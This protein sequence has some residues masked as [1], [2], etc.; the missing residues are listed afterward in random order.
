MLGQPQHV[1]SCPVGSVRQQSGSGQL[2]GGAQNAIA[3]A[4]SCTPGKIR[5]PAARVLPAPM[6]TFSPSTTPP[7]TRQRSP[8]DTPGPMIAELIRAALAHPAAVEQHRA[9]DVGPGGHAH[10]PPQHGP[11]AEDGPREP[12]G[13]RSPP[14]RGRE[15]CRP[16][17]RPHPPSRSAPP[18][19]ASRR[20]TSVRHLAL[21]D[22][23]GGLQVALR[24]CRCRASTRWPRIRTARC[25]PG[26]GTRRARSRCG[27]PPGPSRQGPRAR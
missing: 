6:L 8:I 2:T 19:A 11:P 12:G 4:G 15:R 10:V 5:M 24:A 18:A 16:P 17:R 14:A 7:S 22:V 26:P 23:E 25:R 1:V 9:L 13:S 27:F 3:P 21:E 20:P